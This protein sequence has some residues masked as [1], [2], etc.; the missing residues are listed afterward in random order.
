MGPCAGGVKIA[1]ATRRRVT[2]TPW[3]VTASTSTTAPR[4]RNSRRT[5]RGGRCRSSGERKAP[6]RSL[7][8]IAPVDERLNLWR[9][10]SRSACRTRSGRRRRC[11]RSLSSVRREW[12]GQLAEEVTVTV[13]AKG[14]EAPAAGVGLD[15]LAGV[16]GTERA[17]AASDGTVRVQV[18]AEGVLAEKTNVPVWPVVPSLASASANGPPP[19]T[20]SG[21]RTAV[22]GRAADTRPGRNRRA[23]SVAEAGP[24]TR[25]GR[26]NGHVRRHR[27]R[28]EGRS[29]IAR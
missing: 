15:E 24:P 13:A 18:R 11:G 8:A 21:S 16:E 22:H 6:C 19:G 14:H 12:V 17:T 3:S 7:T 28:Q 27:A 25:R 5:R 4:R 20:R 2:G 29:G 10:L 1:N 26:A 9:P 23:P